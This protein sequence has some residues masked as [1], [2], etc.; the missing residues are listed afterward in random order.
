MTGR[1]ASWYEDE[2]GPLIRSYALTRGRTHSPRPD[3][4]MITLVLAVDTAADL[5]RREPEYLDIVRLCRAPQSVAEVS[6]ALRLPLMVT[7]ILLSDLLA[8]GHLIC[9]SV[10]L[11]TDTGLHNL[12]LLRTVLDGIRNL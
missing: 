1:R 9:R 10:S 7:K 2:A 4:D 8:D 12:D 3:L 11:V 5:R 6:A